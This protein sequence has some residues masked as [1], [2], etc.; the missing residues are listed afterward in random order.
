MAE[1]I[2]IRKVA[3]NRD[4]REFAWFREKFEVNKNGGN[5]LQMDKEPLYEE[6][7]QELHKKHGWPIVAENAPMF[8][9][10][11]PAAPAAPAEPAPDSSPS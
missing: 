6:Q 1:Q 8:E 11:A 5:W 7:A 10:A 4:G 2:R 3:F 9:P